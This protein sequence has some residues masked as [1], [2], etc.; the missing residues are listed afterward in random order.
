ME[1]KVF[2]NKLYIKG[3]WIFWNFDGTPKP[4]LN[5]EELTRQ[6]YMSSVKNP[7][8]ITDKRNSPNVFKGYNRG[9]SIES[10]AC[11]V[12]RDLK[13][14]EIESFLK[15]LFNSNPYEKDE[16]VQ[17]I[18][19]R[20]KDDIP[21]I[22]SENICERIATFFIEEVLK[23]VAKE[24]KEDD[25][26]TNNAFSTIS[27]QEIVSTTSN[28][29]STDQDNKF[30]PNVNSPDKVSATD[31][32]DDSEKLFYELSKIPG[33]ELSSVRN[34]S[35]ELICLLNTLLLTGKALAEEVNSNPLSTTYE[36]CSNWKPLKNTY[37][38]YTD[39]YTKLHTLFEIYDCKVFEQENQFKTSFTIES[40]WR[41]N[42]MRHTS[43]LD[44][45]DKI[46]KYKQILIDISKA[47]E[48]IVKSKR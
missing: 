48:E 1:Y 2:I 21:D 6:L 17:T 15:D 39:T 4:K 9:N 22:T 8:T 38:V 43:S 26:P 3:A 27:N 5:K 25:V 7:S 40:F 47:I 18:C 28:T 11:D 13:E 20:F 16:N 35:K 37:T 46:K 24:I 19:N 36:K 32:S 30:Q 44:T 33:S 12:L 29:D 42:R 31:N 34:Y 14:G 45:L 41:C 23:P 10:I